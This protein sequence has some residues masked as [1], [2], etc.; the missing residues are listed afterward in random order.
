MRASKVEAKVKKMGRRR[1]HLRA[2]AKVNLR[3]EVLGRHED[4]YHFLRTWIYPVSLWDEL[5]LERTAGEVELQCDHPEVPKE[6]LSVK[7]AR[8]FLRE[9]GVEAGVRIYLRKRI[10]VGAGLGGGSSD[11]AATLRGMEVLFGLEVGQ[12]KLREVARRLGADVPFFLWGEASLMGGIGDEQIKALPKLGIWLVLVFP[13]RP[14][15]TAEVYRRFD[16]RLTSSRGQNK[17][18]AELPPK[19]WEDFLYN[20][21]EGPAKEILPLI[22]DIE[23]RLLR[24]GAEVASMSGSGPTVFGIFRSEEE[25]RRACERLKTPDW[26]VFIVKPL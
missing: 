5:V 20:A 24:E 11:A 26:Q 7:A 9:F 17:I 18:L 10:P 12:G 4:G 14:L 23:R 15:S 21:L 19:R 8:A 13:G 22:D 6:D 25:A 16:A 1:V 2:P 3:L